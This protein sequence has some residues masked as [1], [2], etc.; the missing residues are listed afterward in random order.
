MRVSKPAFTLSPEDAVSALSIAPYYP[1]AG[2]IPLRQELQEGNGSAAQSRIWFAS[3]PYALPRCSGCL[4]FAPAVHRYRLRRVRDLN[5]AHATVE[6]LIPHRMVR[7]SRCGIRAEVHDFLS[8][9]RRATVRFERA[10]ADLCRVLPIQHVA[11]H[12]GLSWHTVKEIDKR[13][14]EREVGTPDYDGLRLLAIDEIAVH[15]GQQY[16]TSVLNLETGG[17]VWMGEGRHDATLLGFFEEFT[18]EQRAGIEAIA[19]DMWPPYR[20]AIKEACPQATLVFDLFHIVAKYGR[21]VIDRVRADEAKRQQTESGRR[22]VK[23]SRYLLLRNQESLSEPE[24]LRLSDLLAANH[25]LSTVYI[26]KDQLKQI[27]KYRHVGWARRALR[28]WCDLA[29]ASEIPALRTFARILQRNEDGIV[30]HARYPLHTSRLEGINNKIK[31]IKRQAYGFR[32]DRYFILKV[33]AAFPG[34]L[35]PH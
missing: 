16:M 11:E 9:F 7:C 29:H 27:W 10:V 8:P 3:D 35:H 1:F 17:V 2:V 6:L 15:K 23:G 21:E 33:K 19:T 13:R 24:R 30:A 18:P 14:L 31:V 25:H 12:F 22:L 4:Q 5:L 20:R 26:L 32:D 34:A 28:A